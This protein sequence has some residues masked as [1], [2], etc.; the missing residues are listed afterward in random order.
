A[1]YVHSNMSRIPASTWAEIR[2]AYA[3]GIGLRELARNM[4]IP[5]GD[6]ARSRQAR[7]L[8]AANRNREID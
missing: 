3:S 6:C 1:D 5:A 4:G 2:T 8:D 7:T